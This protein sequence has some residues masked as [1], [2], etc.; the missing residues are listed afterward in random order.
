MKKKIVLLGSTG[1][2]GKSFLNILKKD[3][4][5]CEILLLSVNSN[6]KELLKQLKIFTVKNIIVANKKSYLEIKKK[7][8]NKKINIYNNY[9]LLNKIFKKQK[10]DYILN[11]ISGL[12]GLN[13]T[14]KTIKFT[15]N[16]AI[17]NKESIICGWTLI[18]K[19]LKKFKVKFIPVDSEHFS[20]W[21]LID[22]AKNTDV[23]K[24]F[25]TASGGPFNRFPLNKFNEITIKKALKHP[26]WKMGKKISIDSATLMNKVFEIIEAKK[27]FNYKY[28]QLKILIHP[29]S[30][31]HAIVKFNNGLIKMLM[32]DTNMRI[33]IFNSFYR[34]YEKKIS[35]KNV[36]F[37]ILNNLNFSNV[38]LIKFPV[39]N[40][41][42]KMPNMDSLFETVLVS[43]N[44][45][46]VDLF[47]NKKITFNQISTLLF[48]IIKMKEFSK[49]K[50]LKA[51]NIDE[52]IKLND[53]VSLK[54]ENLTI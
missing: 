26:N 43:A 8:K 9:D 19:E 7:L 29:N 38:D 17:A 15:K 31:V 30:Y 45:K 41:L 4:N 2:I 40:I 6:I 12:E 1:S 53:Y 18:Q 34:N 11:A 3:A 47:L 36:D 21:S 48:K 42:K 13:P 14:L 35:T 10:A 22:N 16:I 33:P 44:D 32:H 20:I 39:V 46:L 5:N 54:I 52:I 28:S 25:I 23:E 24:V 49:F 37:D 27:I 51:K 50:R